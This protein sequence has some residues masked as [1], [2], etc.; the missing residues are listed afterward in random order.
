METQYLP[1]PHS[2]R[3][4]QHIDRVPTMILDTF[5]KQVGLFFCQCSEWLLVWPRGRCQCGR[6]SVDQTS[7]QRFI[8]CL[9]DD[10]MHVLDRSLTQALFEFQRHQ[11]LNIA[12]LDL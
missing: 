9:S 1:L 6:V 5:Q 12:L 11:I 10:R 3:D 2:C 4:S 8:E 7:L